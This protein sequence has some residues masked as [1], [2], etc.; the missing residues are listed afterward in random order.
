MNAEEF[1]QRIPIGTPVL[2]FPSSNSIEF[3]TAATRTEAWELGSGQVV[4]SITGKSGGVSIA[5]VVTSQSINFD[6]IKRFHFHLDTCKQ[7]R[8]NPFALCS[9]G[10]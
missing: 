4:V 5:H 9:V 6:G 1:N 10:D 8:E 7:C 2:Y 3:I